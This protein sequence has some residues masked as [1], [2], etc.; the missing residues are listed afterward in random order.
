MNHVQRGIATDGALLLSTAD[1]TVPVHF[2]TVRIREAAGGRREPP[3]EG[4]A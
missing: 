1:G 2:G 3:A 4:N